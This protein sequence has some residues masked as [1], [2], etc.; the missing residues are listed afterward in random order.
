MKTRSQLETQAFETML[1]MALREFVAELFFTDAGL[2]IGYIN[3]GQA[4]NIED[5]VASSAERS[6]KPGSLRYGRHAMTHSDWGQPPTVSMD[7]EFHHHSL[8]IYFKLVFDATSVGVAID[9]IDFRVPCSGH[10][11]GIELLRAA[12]AD[13]RMPA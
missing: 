11:E 7:L 5:I 2:L 12:L 3:A 13:S 8:A 9:S 10:D 1:A 6:L 4:N